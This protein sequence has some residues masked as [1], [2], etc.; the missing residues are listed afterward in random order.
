MSLVSC[1]ASRIK[2]L[3]GG[4]R[5]RENGHSFGCYTFRAHQSGWEKASRVPAV[6]SFMNYEMILLLAFK[7]IASSDLLFYGLES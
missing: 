5:K 7:A 6:I 1:G 4:G 3:P 2:S